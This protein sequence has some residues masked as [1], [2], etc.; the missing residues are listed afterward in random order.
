M[1]RKFSWTLYIAE[2]PK[3]AF[4]KPKIGTY[5]NYTNLH[6]ITFLTR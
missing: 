5:K 4:F 6:V 3:S 1:T 2:M